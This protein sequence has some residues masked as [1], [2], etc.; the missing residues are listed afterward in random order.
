M[1]REATAA[2]RGLASYALELV[3]KKPVAALRKKG[4]DAELLFKL[5][6]CYAGL[7]DRP[8]MATLARSLRAHEGQLDELQRQRLEQLEARLR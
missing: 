7:G 5:V 3:A 2:A 1:A 8:R 4:W 6:Q